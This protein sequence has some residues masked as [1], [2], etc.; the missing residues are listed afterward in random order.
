MQRHHLI[1]CQHLSKEELQCIWS[2]MHRVL[3]AHKVYSLTS[4]YNF[5]LLWQMDLAA[6]HCAQFFTTR[7]FSDNSQ[8]PVKVQTGGSTINCK[9][10]GVE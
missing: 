1:L 7:H 2:S 9:Q 10:M 3:V 8:G 6:K 5:C 4:S